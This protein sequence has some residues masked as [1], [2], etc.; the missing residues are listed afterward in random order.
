MEPGPTEQENTTTEEKKQ[1][2]DIWSKIKKNC[3]ENGRSKV[4]TEKRSEQG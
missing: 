4:M 3:E 1:L 2:L